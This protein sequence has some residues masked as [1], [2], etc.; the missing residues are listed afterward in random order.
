MIKAS[1]RF[2]SVVHLA[3]VYASSPQSLT[4]WSKPQA[5][6]PVARPV[7]AK[8]GGKGDVA[9]AKGGKGNKGAG[10]KGTRG[11]LQAI[12][13]QTG[14]R[15][16]GG[17]KAG[18]KAAGKGGKKGQVIVGGLLKKY[19]DPPA[20]SLEIAYTHAHT[21]THRVTRDGTLTFSKSTR[22]VPY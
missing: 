21:H 15:Q 4:S 11:N 7:V 19:V 8:K 5:A 17:G 18:G 22:A 10:G 9:A 3:L 14:G 16:A 1:S 2:A 12:L 20:A 13:P 6:A